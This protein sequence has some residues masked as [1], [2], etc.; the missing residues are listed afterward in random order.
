[1]TTSAKIYT[2]IILGQ[3]YD[4]VMKKLEREFYPKWGLKPDKITKEAF[5]IPV[6]YNMAV[7]AVPLI[8]HHLLKNSPTG[9][10]VLIEVLSQKN[11]PWHGFSFEKLGKGLGLD[12]KDAEVVARIIADTL[13]TG[14]IFNKPKR[15]HTDET[16]FTIQLRR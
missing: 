9:K 4:L 6:F 15:L 14:N 1:M 2:Q 8:I 7:D 11:N 10:I 5:R 12:A 3:I 16:E 13:L